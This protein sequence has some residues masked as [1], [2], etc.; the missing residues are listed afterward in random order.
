MYWK[1]E[2]VSGKDH[3]CILEAQG[4]AVCTIGYILSFNICSNFEII[5]AENFL[6]NWL[7][8]L[9]FRFMNYWIMLLMGFKLDLPQG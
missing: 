4:I 9:S 5:S 3:E 8:M 2:T 7:T 1:A 6:L